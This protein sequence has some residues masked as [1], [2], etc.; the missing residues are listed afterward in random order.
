MCLGNSS[1]HG[2]PA[3]TASAPPTPIAHAPRP[4]ALGVCESVPMI[5]A[6]GKAYC[7]N[8]TWWMMPEQGG[9]KTP[10]RIWPT[11]TG[12]NRRPPYSLFR[13]HQVEVTLDP[14]L[15]Q[16][17]AM[18]GGRDR[19]AGAPGLHELEHDGLAQRVLKGHTIGMKC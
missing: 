17:I 19:R 4:P 2:R 13:G 5:S 16:M 15:D 12:E 7:S 14:C 8:T 18:N 11:L 6:P 10:R 1:S 3:M 9:P